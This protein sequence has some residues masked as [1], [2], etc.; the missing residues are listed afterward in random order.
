MDGGVSLCR[1]LNENGASLFLCQLVLTTA[2]YHSLSSVFFD[3]K[4]ATKLKRLK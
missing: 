3:Y 2:L 1:A 4:N